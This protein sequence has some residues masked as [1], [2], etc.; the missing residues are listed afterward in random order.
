M[1]AASQMLVR[2]DLDTQGH[3]ARADAPWRALMTGEPTHAMYT[4]QLQRVYGFEAPVEGALA[5][6]PQLPG[7]WRHRARTGLVAMDLLELGVSPSQIARLPQ[8]DAIAPFRGHVEALGWLYVVER[9][10][11]F[12][13][14]VRS[15]L[16][17]R[18]EFA[19]ACAYLV[20]SSAVAVTRWRALGAVLDRLTR[21]DADLAIEAAHQAFTCQRIWFD[22]EET[23]AI[24]A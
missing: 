5:Y 21:D 18:P 19:N 7:E 22:D 15:N 3:H 6:T 11:L 17:R 8:C 14:A 24:V 9:T 16:V 10:A 13:A 12:L 1:P 23:A 2:L 20:A 4:A